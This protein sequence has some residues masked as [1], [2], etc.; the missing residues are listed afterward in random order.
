MENSTIIF[1]GMD[2]HKEST[3]V[4]Y[5]L[6]GRDNTPQYLG[7]F[8]SRKL[9]MQKLV[10]QLQSKYP[11][12]DLHF[13][14]EAGPCGYWLYRLLAAMNQ[15][16]YVVAPSLIPKKP[17]DHVKTDKRDSLMLT[18][19][20]KS[21]DLYPIYVPAEGDEAIR[22]LSRARE[23][24]MRDLNDARYRLKALL[25][26][27][28][29]QYK[30]TANW[31][32]KHLRWLAEIVLPHH[33][34]QYVLQE[35]IYTISERNER[36]ARLDNELLI[37]VKQWRYYPVVQAIQAMRGVRLLVAVGVIAELGD[38]SRFD[39]PSKLMSYVG[40]TPSE[41]TSG[42]RRRLGGLTKAGNSRARRLLI[43][44][45]HA[46]RFPAK[47]SREIQVR[48]EGLPKPVIDT[49]WRAQLRLCRR[50][51]YMSQ[52]GKNSNVIKAAI[53][54]EMIAFIWSIAREIELPQT[55]IA[56]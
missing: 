20:L 39:H 7:K 35:M 11:K 28:H 16:C 9:A 25:L 44:G 26:R 10:R 41:Y 27:N 30:G 13:C 3:D 56:A 31:G 46:Y 36:L 52:R 54:R 2:T 15:R 55:A 40:L 53:A 37:Q 42:D 51:R 33:A 32:A 34:Q 43:E 8:P 23:A 50:Y 4:S 14:Y 6:E 22:D 21:G 17:G 19:L 49:A 5:A 45:A 29:I 48:H 1:V 47:V 38:L 12:A 18:R 24:A